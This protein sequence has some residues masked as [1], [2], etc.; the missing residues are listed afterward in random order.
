MLLDKSLVIEFF[1][2]IALEGAGRSGRSSRVSLPLVSTGQRPA[3]QPEKRML[4]LRRCQCLRRKDDL[5]GVA[6]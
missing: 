2:G 6:S 4:L 3:L 5:D 1:L